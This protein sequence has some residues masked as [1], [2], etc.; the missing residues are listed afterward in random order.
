[1][2]GLLIP[3]LLQ[4]T[5]AI[6][7]DKESCSTGPYAQSI[8]KDRKLAE[9]RKQMKEYLSPREIGD[10][11]MSAVR[12]CT[13]S[14]LGPTKSYQPT[15]TLDIYPFAVRQCLREMMEGALDRV[16]EK[17]ESTSTADVDAAD[18][19]EGRATSHQMSREHH[20]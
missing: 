17:N 14:A 16:L 5:P 4:A 13:G 2:I 9:L 18:A 15:K 19:S 10:F 7:M 12:I 8:C 6:A 20:P 1:M 11:D 3:L